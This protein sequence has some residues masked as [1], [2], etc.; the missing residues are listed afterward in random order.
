MRS[1]SL[2]SRRFRSRTYDLCQTRSLVPEMRMYT[3]RGSSALSSMSCDAEHK[4]PLCMIAHADSKPVRQA[5]QRQQPAR[6]TL[7]GEGRSVLILSERNPHDRLI[8]ATT[9][10]RPTTR[11]SLLSLYTRRSS[12]A[13]LACATTMR[14]RIQRLQTVST[15]LTSGR[16]GSKNR[17]V[18][19]AFSRFQQPVL[20]SIGP[21]RATNSRCFHAIWGFSD[22]RARSST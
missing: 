12:R 5:S 16:I 21:T 10:V 7:S 20:R 22:S 6:H 4:T 11:P 17:E 1:C 9:C 18:K 14:L 2:Q 3:S 15:L 8:G 13:A 19:S